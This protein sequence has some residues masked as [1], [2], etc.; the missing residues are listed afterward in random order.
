MPVDGEH[1]VHVW[2][3]NAPPLLLLLLLLLFGSHAGEPSRCSLALAARAV[4]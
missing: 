4:P 1:L 2:R 3:D